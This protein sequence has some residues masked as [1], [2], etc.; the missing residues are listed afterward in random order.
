LVIFKPVRLIF[1]FMI[2]LL[3]LLHTTWFSHV[4]R[5]SLK[6]DPQ[7]RLQV[8]EKDFENESQSGT[9][10]KIESGLPLKTISEENSCSRSSKAGD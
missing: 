10:G 9:E 2:F 7:L 8:C 4:G 3:Q 5:K 6:S 1:I